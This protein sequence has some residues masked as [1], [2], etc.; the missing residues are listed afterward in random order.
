[1]GVMYCDWY[2]SYVSLN[3]QDEFMFKF[4]SSKINECIYC[5]RIL[6][7]FADVPSLSFISNISSNMVFD[8]PRITFYK[9]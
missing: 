2:D 9:K 8:H 3:G 1:M 7:E 4:A 6:E 5:T